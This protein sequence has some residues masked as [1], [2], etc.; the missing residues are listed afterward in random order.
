M[1]KLLMAFVLV[2]VMSASAFAAGTFNVIEVRT[3]DPDL[4]LCVLENRTTSGKYAIFVAD[5]TNKKYTT[6][7]LLT[8]LSAG[9]TVSANF[10]SSGGKTYFRTIRLHNE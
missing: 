7:V 6:S 5:N 4:V 3:V 10:V 9:K 1:K 8:A 2:L